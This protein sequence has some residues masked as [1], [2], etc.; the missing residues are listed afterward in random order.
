VN[1]QELSRR[2]RKKR[3]NRARILKAAR[4]LFQ[5]QGFDTTSIEEIAETADISKST[6]FNYFPSKE[7][8]LVEIAAQEVRDLQRLLTVDLAEVPSAVERIHRAM[9]LLVADTVPRLRLTRRVLLYT[10]LRSSSIPTPVAQV[11]ALFEHLVKQAQVQ[12]E[13]RADLNP[14]DVASVL[15]GVYFATFSRRIAA[16]DEQPV[17]TGPELEACLRMLFEGIIGPNYQ[18]KRE[19]QE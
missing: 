9:N 15:T 3:E 4:G 14:P 18:W 17:N 2:E 12:G 6:F 10:M 8:L 13:I 1:E 5:A 7:S 19:A 11:E 16:A